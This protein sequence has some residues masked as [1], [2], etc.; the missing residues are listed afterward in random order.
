LQ[1]EGLALLRHGFQQR[2]QTQIGRVSVQA[3]RGVSSLCFISLSIILISIFRVN[4]FHK[5]KFICK[6]KK[7]P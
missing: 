1:G 6:N 4:L 7:M 5:K 3:S 2:E